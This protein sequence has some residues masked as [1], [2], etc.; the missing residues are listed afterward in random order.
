MCGVGRVVKGVIKN[1][2]E[3]CDIK[4]MAH[5]PHIEIIIPRIN[6]MS[7]PYAIISIYN[8]EK[9]VKWI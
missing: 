6:R 1:T 8:N 4:H 7:V 5:A 9:E 2:L 3:F